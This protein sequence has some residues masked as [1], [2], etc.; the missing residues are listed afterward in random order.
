MKKKNTL[1]IKELFLNLQEEMKQSLRICRNHIDHPGSKGDASENEWINWLKEYLPKRYMVDKAFVIDHEGF[2]SEQIDVVIYDRQYSPFVFHHLGIK[3]IPAESVYAVFE[4]KQEMDKGNIEYTA[5]KIESVR[6]LTRTSAPIVHAGGTISNPK[7]PF[8]II[9]G[10]LTTESGW[11]P[12]L[13]E[14][15]ES[16]ILSLK[17]HQSI[18]IGCSITDGSFRVLNEQGRVTIQKCKEDEVL[19]FFFLNLL[20]EL[21]NRGTAPAMDILEYAKALESI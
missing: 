13:G 12:P 17:G 19:I 1:D 4:V 7:K 15:F 3:Y 18:N 21:Q 14:S 11:N 6:E 5:G 20:I 10:I 8:E 9:G 2:V 16:L